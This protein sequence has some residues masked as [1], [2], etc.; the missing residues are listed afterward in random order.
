MP[1]IVAHADTVPHGPAP[2]RFHGRSAP[3]PLPPPR[4]TPPRPSAPALPCTAPP[5][6][7]PPSRAAPHRPTLP[8][9]PA[10]LPAPLRRPTHRSAQPARIGTRADGSARLDSGPLHAAAAQSIARREPPGPTAASRPGRARPGQ[11]AQLESSATARGQ[12]QPRRAAI[13]DLGRRRQNPR[14][15]VPARSPTSPHQR[16]ARLGSAP[17]PPCPAGWAGSES[18]AE[19]TVD[20]SSVSPCHGASGRRPAF[21]V[22]R[23]AFTDLRPAI[24]PGRAAAVRQLRARGRWPGRGQGQ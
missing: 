11:A 22:R 24:L 10:P 3:P 6:A 23:P 19:P 13:G 4:P 1:R 18:A 2:R 15:R 5:P 16:V 14:E 7:P 8:A 12:R 9:P 17:V 20:A 21:R